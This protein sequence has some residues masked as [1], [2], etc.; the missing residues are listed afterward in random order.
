M[1]LLEFCSGRIADMKSLKANVDVVN[2]KEMKTKKCDLKLHFSPSDFSPL[3]DICTYVYLHGTLVV[4]LKKN[5]KLKISL[6]VK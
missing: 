4:K 5:E 3:W 2:P 1:L 6:D